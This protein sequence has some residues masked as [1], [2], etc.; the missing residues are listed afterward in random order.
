[1]PGPEAGLLAQAAAGPGFWE[2]WPGELR[3]EGLIAELLADGVIAA[4][5]AEADH[6][7]QL[8]RVLT[9]G[10]TAMCVITGALFHGQ[11]QGYDMILA[12]AFK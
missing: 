3:R 10:V 9:A 5:A 2:D 6:G 8:D 12:K 11:G 1:M 4:A 7:H